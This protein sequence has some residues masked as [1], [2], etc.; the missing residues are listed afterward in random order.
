MDQILKRFHIEACNARSIPLVPASNSLSQMSP[1]VQAAALYH[2][3]VDVL[4]WKA[5]WTSPG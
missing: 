2:E 3:I 1:D 4:G 5:N